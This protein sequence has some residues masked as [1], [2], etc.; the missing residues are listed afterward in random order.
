MSSKYDKEVSTIA[1]KK[2]KD[3]TPAQKAKRLAYAK[4]Y[5]QKIHAAARQAGVIGAPR[6]KLSEAERKGKRKV[7][8]KAYRQKIAAQAAAYRRLQEGGTTG[9]KK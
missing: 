1:T 7:Y 6:P 8:A 5:R 2:Y 3:L 9:R 4:A